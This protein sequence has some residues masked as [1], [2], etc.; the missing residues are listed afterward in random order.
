[1]R[2]ERIVG[3]KGVEVY[4]RVDCIFLWVVYIPPVGPFEK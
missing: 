4:A 3:E 1:M 2:R